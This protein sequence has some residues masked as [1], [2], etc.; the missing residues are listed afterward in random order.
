MRVAEHPFQ[1]YFVPRFGSLKGIKQKR[2]YIEY[3]EI[4]KRI[5]LLLHIYIY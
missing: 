2:A 5:N 1:S 3:I 4:Q